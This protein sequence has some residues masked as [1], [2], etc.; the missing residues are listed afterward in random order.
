MS[1][2]VKEEQMDFPKTLSEAIQKGVVEASGEKDTAYLED[3]DVRKSEDII[4]ES[5]I[6]FLA[7]KFATSMA[8]VYNRELGNEKYFEKYFKDLWENCTGRK[9]E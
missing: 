8:I 1:E 9:I 7:Q 2:K 3:R 5:V 4:F 6:D